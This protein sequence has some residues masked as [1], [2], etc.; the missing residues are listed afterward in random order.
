MAEL[1]IDL[2]GVAKAAAGA[3]MPGMFG[4]EG[5]GAPGVMPAPDARTGP[6]TPSTTVSPAIQ[7]QISPQISPVMTQMQASPGAGVQAAPTM[8][9]GGAQTVP[10]GAPGLPPP[11][12]GPPQPVTPYY[13]APAPGIPFGTPS[14]FQTG[15]QRVNWTLIAIAGAVAVG[16]IAIFGR[17]RRPR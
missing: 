3:F 17:R 2:I 5:N 1:G 6:G 8:Y 15:E 14:A 10:M 4:P 13:G 7:T 11:P 16:A 12:M 9:P